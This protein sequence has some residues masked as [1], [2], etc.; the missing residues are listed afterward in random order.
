MARA[1][2]RQ[3]RGWGQVGEETSRETGAADVTTFNAHVAAETTTFNVHVAAE[4]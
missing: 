3:G 1:K 2:S 4:K